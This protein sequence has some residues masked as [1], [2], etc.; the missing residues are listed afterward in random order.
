[1][2]AVFMLGYLLALLIGISL[3]LLGG[4]GSIL[5]VPILVYALGMDPKVSIG[6]SLAIV[7]VTSL[8]G[9]WSHYRNGNID[10]KIAGIFA[11][12]A[13][14]GT[15]MGAKLSVFISAQTQL[16]LFAIIMLAAAY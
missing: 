4:G 7:G 6:L 14:L 8:I 5:T 2:M 15:F 3:G 9:I 16:L 13:M 12:F 10:F 11:P 1:M